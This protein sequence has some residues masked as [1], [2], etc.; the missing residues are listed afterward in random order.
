MEKVRE[1][2]SDSQ[3]SLPACMFARREYTNKLTHQVLSEGQLP[4]SVCCRGGDDLSG[5]IRLNSSQD[6]HLGQNV[7]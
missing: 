1:C 3:T 6:T 2:S 4:V 5:H 7:I